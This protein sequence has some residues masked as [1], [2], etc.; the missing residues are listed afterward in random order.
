MDL[1]I[2]GLFCEFAY[3]HL[4][5]WS[6][7][8]NFWSK[9]VFLSAN[10][11]F[12][13]QNSRTYLPRITRPTC[14]CKWWINFS[15]Q[16]NYILSSYLPKIWSFMYFFQLGD[17][18]CQ[19]GEDDEM[20]LRESHQSF[21]LSHSTS[22]FSQGCKVLQSFFVK[23]W[24]YCKSMSQSYQTFCL[25]KTKIFFLFL[26]LSLSV[27][28]IRKCCLYFKMAKLKSENQKIKVW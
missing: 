26:L 27:C 8:R 12:A 14:T 3:S 2:R 28:N 6:K 17:N 5:R 18:C 10:S 20:A 4:K 16:L 7:R 13:V 9:Y 1:V 21:L 22:K 11:V 25:R 19:Q 23:F 24:A 15:I